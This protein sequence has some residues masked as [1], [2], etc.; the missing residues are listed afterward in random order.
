MSAEEAFEHQG[1]AIARDADFGIMHHQKLSHVLTGE[2]S[3]LHSAGF[4]LLPLGPK[5]E[6]LVRFKTAAGVPAKR[7]PLSLVI[8]KMAGAGSSN[9]AIRLDGLLVVDV[10]SDTPDARAYVR[11]RFGDSSVQVKSPRGIHHYYRHD[12]KAPKA[13]RLPGI[14]IDFKTGSQSLIAGPYAERADGG[15]YL[16]LKGQLASV[17]ALSAFSDN[18]LSHEEDCDSPPPRTAGG[19]IARGDRHQS[20]KKRGMQLI[21][22]AVDGADLFD[23]LRLYRDWECEFPE[24]VPDSEVEALARWFWFKRCNNEIWGGRHS[25]MGMS[26]ASL[27]QLLNVKYGDQAWMLYSYVHSVHEHLGR[28]FSIVPE[29]IL[30]AGKL[31]ALSAKD[32]RRAAH[33]LVDH[34][35][36]WR[37]EVRDGF[38]RKYLYRI[39]GGRQGE[40]STDYINAQYGHTGLKVYEGGKSDSP[41]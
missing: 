41:T 3:R 35:L 16:P 28:E 17:S 38:K 8:E 13:V 31:Q 18:D 10:D 12:G 1:D 11:E 2:M 26:R 19:K 36:L 34:R 20:L 4:S 39:A 14:A 22:T 21:H 25:P 32:I 37:R 15:Q 27:D 6:P 5:R 40:R 23:N 30:A 9:Y 24:E 7:L 29:A 33:I